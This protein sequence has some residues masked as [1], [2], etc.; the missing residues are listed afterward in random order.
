MDSK[1]FNDIIEWAVI[2]FTGLSLLVPVLQYVAKQTATK[3]DDELVEKL[4]TFLH[5]ALA[6][7]P[8]A[9][10][11]RTLGQKEVLDNIPAKVVEQAPA[12]SKLP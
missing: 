12:A 5:D 7:L 9:R 11:G 1:V 3:T 2:I 6:F 4:A 10:R 8:V